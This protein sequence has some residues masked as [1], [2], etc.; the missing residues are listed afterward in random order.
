MGCFPAC[1]LFLS[2]REGRLKAE[3]KDP[4]KMPCLV[5]V[6]FSIKEGVNGKSM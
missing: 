2:S 5:G 1:F 3:S 4:D 6:N